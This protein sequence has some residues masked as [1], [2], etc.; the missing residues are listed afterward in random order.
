M[1]YIYHPTGHYEVGLKMGGH[2]D[3]RE[4]VRIPEIVDTYGKYYVKI[5]AALKFHRSQNVR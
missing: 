2:K 5:H 1:Q 3:G 4:P